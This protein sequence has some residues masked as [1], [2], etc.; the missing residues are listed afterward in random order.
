MT[1]Q[2]RRAHSCTSSLGGPRF[3]FSR[4]T[5]EGQILSEEWGN[6]ICSTTALPYL[7]AILV[8]L[9]P[10]SELELLAGHHL[11]SEVTPDQW[12]RPDLGSDEDACRM[13]GD[14]DE[15][16][17]HEKTRR[18]NGA[19]GVRD[20]EVRAPRRTGPVRA[21]RDA[22]GSSRDT[23]RAG[24]P[25][26]GPPQRPARRDGAGLV[27]GLFATLTIPYLFLPP[28]YTLRFNRLE[29]HGRR[30]ELAGNIGVMGTLVDNTE[31]KRAE[32]EHRVYL[33]FLES[34]DKINRA[35]QGSNDLE[36]L[37]QGG[38]SACIGVLSVSPRYGVL[39]YLLVAPPVGEHASTARPLASTEN[40]RRMCHAA[41]TFRPRPAPSRPVFDR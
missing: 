35:M 29:V 24:L 34:L 6:Q 17:R 16:S 37:P 12:G 21:A 7:S 3:R 18:F 33:W 25:A 13:G 32:E 39:P 23:G 30:I 27:A 19:D 31:R 36:A 41:Q 14:G 26:C 5:P 4:A 22:A 2:R 11:I 38:S 15:D 28:K 1:R 40:N 9:L 10:R 8:A 20:E